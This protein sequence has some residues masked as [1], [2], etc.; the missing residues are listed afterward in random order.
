MVASSLSESASRRQCKSSMESLFRLFTQLM[1][2]QAPLLSE[3][4]SLQCWTCKSAEGT[5]QFMLL[6][7]QVHSDTKGLLLLRQVVT[8]TYVYLNVFHRHATVWGVE[9]FMTHQTSRLVS[10]GACGV[11]Q[12]QA[13]EHSAQKSPTAFCQ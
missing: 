1:A 7:W 10:T 9:P 8:Q 13:A 11:G 2:L 4:K 6:L 5:I 12:D 3:K